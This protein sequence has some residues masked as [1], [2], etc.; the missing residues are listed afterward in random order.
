MNHAPP[1]IHAERRRDFI[2]IVEDVVEAIC[3]LGHIRK[4]GEDLILDDQIVTP[5]ILRIYLAQHCVFVDGKRR[6]NGP[7]LPVVHAVLS[8]AHNGFVPVREVES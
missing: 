7:P 3:A 5:R 8:R 2:F 6:R 1:I 4:R